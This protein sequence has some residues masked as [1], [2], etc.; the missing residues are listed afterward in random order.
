MQQRSR[1]C[2]G[3]NG[4]K[5]QCMKDKSRTKS[6]MCVKI[7]TSAFRSDG[8]MP[9]CRKTLLQVLYS[10]I[11][12]SKSTKVKASKYM[13]ANQIKSHFSL[14][15]ISLLH[16]VTSEYIVSKIYKLKVQLPPLQNYERD[17]NRQL[18]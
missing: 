7:S 12:L 18:S 13:E 4:S 16:G 15:P 10:K 8:A 14:K 5:L 17:N 6:H 3:V 9:K 1:S 11:Y 2:Q